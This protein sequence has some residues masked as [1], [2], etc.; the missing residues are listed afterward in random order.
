M[1]AKLEDWREK[2]E[3]AV[4]KPEGPWKTLLYFT[5]D[6]VRQ[7]DSAHGLVLGLW[8]PVLPAGRTA[9]TTAGR[10]ECARTSLKFVSLVYAIRGGS[11]KT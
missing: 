2:V 8:V 3:R 7:R 9:C 1:Y 6:H 4:K 11:G 5:Y 10:T